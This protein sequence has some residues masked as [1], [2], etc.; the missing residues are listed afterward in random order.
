[1]DGRLA[2]GTEN[3]G[4]INELQSYDAYNYATLCNQQM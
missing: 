4:S 3:G 1:M 2:K